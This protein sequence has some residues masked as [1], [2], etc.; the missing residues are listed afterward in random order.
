[1][2]A[3]LLIVLLGVCGSDCAMA[4]PAKAPDD[5]DDARVK[6]AINAKWMVRVEVLMVQM[7]QA[8][9]LALLPGL[10]DADTADEAFAKVMAAI[11]QKQATLVGYPVVRALDGLKS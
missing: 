4:R 1:M 11:E 5:G 6:K 8:Q 9:A 10:R 3:L 2:R 7:P